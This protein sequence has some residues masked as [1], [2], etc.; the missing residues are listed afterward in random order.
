MKIETEF[1]NGV[2]YELYATNKTGVV[3][4]KE[5]FCEFT[6]EPHGEGELLIRPLSDA[7]PPIRMYNMAL[8]KNIVEVNDCALPGRAVAET[9]TGLYLLP[10]PNPLVLGCHYHG[11]IPGRTLREVVGPVRVRHW[12][13]AVNSNPYDPDVLNGSGESARFEIVEGASNVKRGRDSE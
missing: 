3:N 1:E 9:L 12:Y 5:F 4:R 8:R 7:S 13:V 6:I 2:E 11:L 10:G